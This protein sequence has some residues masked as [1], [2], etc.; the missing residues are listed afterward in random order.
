MES[1]VFF[2]VLT[3]L[4]LSQN[5]KFQRVVLFFSAHPSVQ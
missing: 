4:E 5:S 1:L 2:L 3:F